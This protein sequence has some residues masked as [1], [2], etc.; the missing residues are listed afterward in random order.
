[1]TTLLAY[2][3]SFSAA[4]GD[5]V[6][7]MVS[8][9]GA[10]RY[11]AEIVRLLNPEAGPE[12]TAFRTEPV[13]TPVNGEHPGRQQILCPGS[14]GVVEPHPKLA[15]LTS[16]TLQ[17]FVWPTTPGRGTQG[18][19]GSWCEGDGS[20]FGLGLDETGAASAYL[21]DG[22]GGRV[23]ASTGVPLET[24]RWYFV[25]ATFDAGSGTL[26]VHQAPLPDHT[27]RDEAPVGSEIKT[28]VRPPSSEVPFLIGASNG[29]GPGEP[30]VAENCFNGKLDR[31]RLA[32]R[33]LSAAEREQLAR[34]ARLPASLSSAVV[35][36]WDFW[37]GMETDVARDCSGNRLDAALVNLPARA[38]T[39][40]NWTGQHMRWIDAPEQYGAIHFHDDDLVD[41]GWSP[42]FSFQI[43]AGLRS[44]VYSVRLRAE[45]AEFWVPFFVRPPPGTATAK[46]AFLA[47]T[48]TY[49]VYG[50]NRGR[51]TSSAAELYH[52]RL[53]LMDAIDGLFFSHPEIGVSTYDRHSDGSGVCYASRHRPLLNVRPTGRHWNF[54]LDLFIVDWL[55][56]LDMPYDVITEEDLHEEG[57]ALLEPYAVVLTGSH[58]E[59]DSLEMLDALN[60]YVH[61]GGRLMYMGGNGF[62][63]RIAHHPTRRGVLE[64]RR[65]EDG[66]RAW[67][68]EPGEYYHSFSGEYGG[69]WRRQGRSPHCLAGVGFISQGFDK[70]S[71][72]RRTDQ[73][74]DPRVSFMFEGIDDELIGDFG[75]LQGGAAGLEIDSADSALG[76]PAHALIVARSENHSNTYE[77]VAEEV[78][79][80]HGA[81]NAVQNP[82]IHADLMFFETRGGGAVFST[83]SIAF[84]GSLGWNGF[85][86]NVAR[87]TTNVLKRFV[88]LEPFALPAQTSPATEAGD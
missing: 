1:M 8:C 84:S 20:G 3:D 76:T 57:L 22:L 47:S 56:H 82:N 77:L 12:A 71:Y 24:R 74:N 35:A 13:D 18:L 33:A 15:G 25:S 80:P 44:G 60:A 7:C 85:N 32:D 78:R 49:T 86:N 41:A 39:G 75:I 59:Y 29:A 37:H 67:D 79:V 61:R 62:Y 30:V 83:G 45:E 54:N 69:L 42:D 88:D 14:Y 2:C 4:P 65:A 27:F 10:A 52:G 48:A 31:P 43:P 53:T 66:I 11:H 26:A 6:N 55:E 51:F 21:G 19:L 34:D 40:H 50:N 46:I 58:P 87:L 23:S 81:T 38:M 9:E 36:R 16:F 70:C 64:V 68:A 63:W 73:S 28:A 5:T 17:T 72:Y